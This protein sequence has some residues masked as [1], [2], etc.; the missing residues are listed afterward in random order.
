MDIK[1]GRNVKTNVKENYV[2]ALLLCVEWDY[3]ERNDSG[4]N[5]YKSVKRLSSIPPRILVVRLEKWN[6]LF[7][8]SF[9]HM[10]NM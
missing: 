5:P 8:Y 6:N 9:F 7:K 3:F 4:N 1:N 2:L 10:Q